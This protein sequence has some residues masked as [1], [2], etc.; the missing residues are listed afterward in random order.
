MNTMPNGKTLTD[1]KHVS[2]NTDCPEQLITPH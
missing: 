1:F 2:M